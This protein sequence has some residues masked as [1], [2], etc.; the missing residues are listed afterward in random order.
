MGVLS[1]Q[2]V[3]ED[4]SQRKA[5]LYVRY[6]SKGLGGASKSTS[7]PLQNGPRPINNE[8]QLT[9]RGG[10]QDERD[11]RKP[12]GDQSLEGRAGKASWE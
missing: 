4:T 1:N 11:G 10:F 9:E 2:A 3:F 6:E 5:I 8:L 7:Q 12:R